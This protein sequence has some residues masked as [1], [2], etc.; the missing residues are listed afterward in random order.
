MKLW[1]FIWIVIG[2]LVAF[3]VTQTLGQSCTQVDGWISDSSTGEPLPGA[4]VKINN[5]GGTVT[6]EEGYFSLAIFPTEILSFSFMGFDEIKIDVAQITE[7]QLNIRLIPSTYV[8]NEVVIKGDRLIA[9]EF[10]TTSINKLDIYKNPSSK[11]DPILAV[12]ALPSSTTLDESA[13]ISLRGSTT[14]ETGIFLNDV[15][16]YDA[17]RYGQLNGIGTFSIFNTALIKRVTVFPGNPPLEYG[18]TASGLISLQTDSYIP[19]KTSTQV[20]LTLAS[21]GVFTN[22]PTGKKSS[23]SIF[24][25]YQPSALIKGINPESLESIKSFKSID[26]G[27][28]GYKKFGSSTELKVFNYSLSESYTFHYQHPSYTGDFDQDKKRNFTVASLQHK[29][30]SSLFS[31][32][33]GLSFS[34]ADFRYSA[35]QINLRLND[36][37]GSANYWL[38]KKS[39]ELKTGLSLDRRTSDFAGT[40]PEFSYAQAPHHP[41]IQGEAQQT[42]PL[43]ELYGYIK[44]NI[45]EKII[46]GTGLRKNI[47]SAG[48]EDYMSLQANVRYQ[49]KEHLALLVGAGQYHRYAF[50]ESNDPKLI[51]SR[52]ASLDALLTKQKF[53]MTASIYYK[54][55][56]SENTS[57]H[58]LGGELF[59]NYKPVPRFQ[60]QLSLTTLDAIV[61]SGDTESRSPYDIKYFIRGNAQY[62]FIPTWTMAMVFLV[63]QGR[64]YYP[65]ESAQFVP[66]LDVFEPVTSSSN[67]NRLPGYETINLSLTKIFPLFNRMTAIAFINAQNT[68]NSKNPSV[69]VNNRDFTSTSFDLYSLRTWYFGLILAF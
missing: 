43:L 66:A 58:V 61:Y 23:I 3:L 39:L 4:H 14:E 65:V 32:N 18:N 26:L 6:N 46:L 33:Q 29:S 24:S 52:Q 59:V 8:V 5:R 37:Y 36:Y 22:I 13:N 27:V 21:F 30:G 15:P 17:V 47:V 44:K 25:N 67:Q 34:H 57:Y 7:C 50:S 68:L 49:V 28:H 11:A 35:T 12:N 31:L 64:W 60:S 51:Q 41:V 10:K 16:L 53:E 63:R 40:Y 42:I 48:Q 38:V 19:P 9:E 62:E 1:R 54:E 69:I 20:S 55:N 45:N 56:E 2:I